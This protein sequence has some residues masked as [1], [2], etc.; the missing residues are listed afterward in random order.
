M[1]ANQLF[2]EQ[3]LKIFA[4]ING[5]HTDIEALKER[6][7]VSVIKTFNNGIVTET[8]EFDSFDGN[9][10]FTK[11]HSYAKKGDLCTLVQELEQKIA[12]AVEIEHYELAAELKQQKD[13]LLRK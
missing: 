8:I 4:E 11:V 5:E 1:N 7:A 9:E 6:G 3:E 13:T 2:T 10:Y 12:E